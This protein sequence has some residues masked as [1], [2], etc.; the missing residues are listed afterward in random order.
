MRR[1]LAAGAVLFV[2][3]V[4][5]GIAATR[6]GGP[7]RPAPEQ[8]AA[9]ATAEITRGD[10]VDTTS[11]DG[12]L[13]YSGE[14]EVA[15][16]A[17]GTVTRMPAPGA[18]IRQGAALYEVDRR[19]TVL[20]YGT[21]PLY[22][23]LR[24]GIA[25]GP[26]VRQLERAL[27]ILGHGR[28]LTV[29]RHFSFATAQAVR[30]WQGDNGLEKTGSVDAAQVRFLPGQ[31]RIGQAK[32]AVGDRVG[33]GRAVLT[34]TSDRRIVHVDLKASEQGLAKKGAPVTVGLPDG[35]SVAGRI[36]SVGTV[37]EKAEPAGDSGAGGQSREA[38]VDVEIRLDDARRT[39]RLDQAPVT[40][41]LESARR[42]NVLSV[43]VEALLALREG[44]YG[45]EVVDPGGARRV[46]A[47]RTGAYGGGRVE[48]TGS[49]LSEGMKIG[50]PAL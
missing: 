19:K 43:P 24:Q 13:T 35:T 12:T 23:T 50:V 34:V 45:V 10:L 15:A 46:A 39:G 1:R 25:D 32:A 30:R 3:A 21:V 22:R 8:P 29:D 44:G 2:A 14:R 47:V 27:R 42:E 38:T 20:M 36:A 4:G 9:P 26:D 7:D 40:V 28:D 49:G 37:A 31:V 41:T 5:G 17:A 48:I 16:M 11:V 18:L 6:A 33:P